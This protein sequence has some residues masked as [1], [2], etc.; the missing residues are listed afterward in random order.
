MDV[1]P[2]EF[3]RGTKTLQ[4]DVCCEAIYQNFDWLRSQKRLRKFAIISES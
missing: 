4:F 3:E 2:V 1:L